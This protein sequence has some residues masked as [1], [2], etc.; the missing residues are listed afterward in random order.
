MGKRLLYPIMLVYLLFLI[1]PL[2]GT[3]Q[4]S[5][6]LYSSARST[7]QIFWVDEDAKGKRSNWRAVINNFR[8]VYKTYP[9]APEAAKTFYMVGKLSFY[10]YKYHRN[11]D[12][13]DLGIEALRILITRYPRNS[14]VDDARYFIGELYL[15]SGQPKLAAY[16]YRRVIEDY[17]D[18]DMKRDAKQRLEQMRLWPMPEWLLRYRPTGLA[19]S[20]DP[21]PDIAPPEPPSP[22]PLP[23]GQNPQPDKPPL[24]T[25]SSGR[26]LIKEIKHFSSGSYTRVVIYCKHK[27]SYSKPSYIP[28]APKDGV[29]YPRLFLDINDARIAPGVGNPRDINDGLLRRVRAGQ[30]LPDV[31]RV[32]L[33]IDSIDKNQTR[34]IPMEEN[35]GDFRIVIDVTGKA[36]RGKSN[37]NNHVVETGP[38]DRFVRKIVLDPG[39][40]GKDP[41]AVGPRK[42]KEKDIML[43]V[44]LKTA[45]ALRGKTHADVLLTRS[46]DRYL[47]LEERTAY[48]N[49]VGADVFVSLH[50][51][52]HP[53]RDARGTETY[54]LDTTNDRSA[55]RLAALENR[56]SLDALMKLQKDPLL[57]TLFQKAKA[58]ESYELARCVHGSMIRGLRKKYRDVFDHGL[59]EAP[60]FV[61]MGATMPCVLVEASF[62]S[63][64]VEEK[65]LASEKYQ[66]VLADS[67]AEGI[68]EFARRREAGQI[69]DL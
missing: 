37:S 53:N 60:F 41:G 6:A 25:I 49:V 50:A 65:R 68:A 67:I 1:I 69:P 20:V 5:A 36:A 22:A 16:H 43:K 66:N 27:V 33:D 8:K 19:A 55:N 15:K 32:V 61:L 64:P 17:P 44:A 29:N 34:I 46:T 57:F 52:A 10:C 11:S 14:L 2:V 51:N 38:E 48:A 9:N 7:Y 23:P 56:V 28:P 24:A 18:G 21:S 12:D 63:N 13:F 26:V 35:D 30:N 31:V 3:A 47:S 40:G 4:D 42:F 54:I 58:D 45:R 62:I 59:K 39:H